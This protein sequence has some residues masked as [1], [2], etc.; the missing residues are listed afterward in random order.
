MLSSVNKSKT[1]LFGAI[2]NLDKNNSDKADKTANG[3]C[4]N[5]SIFGKNKGLQDKYQAALAN[6]ENSK[7]M[8]AFVDE[9]LNNDINDD[10][11]VNGSVINNEIQNED[12]NNTKQNISKSFLSENDIIAILKDHDNGKGNVF[13]NSSLLG[14]LDLLDDGIKN[15][16]VDS[17]KYRSSVVESAKQAV[18]TEEAKDLDDCN[19]DNYIKHYLDPKDKDEE[20]RATTKV[21]LSPEALLGK[22]TKDKVLAIAESCLGANE[23]DGSYLKFGESSHWC[24]AFVNYVFTQANNGVDP[25]SGDAKGSHYCPNYT[26][27]AQTP[28]SQGKTRWTTKS[29]DV[30][31]GDI[32]MFSND[33]KTS[34]HIGIIEKIDEDG[35]IHTI[36]GNTSDTCA[37]RK[38]AAGDSRVQGFIKMSG[39]EEKKAA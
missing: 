12:I 13:T 14:E 32:I 35:T 34:S 6:G 15:T 9:Y 4:G 37:R 39:S 25:F 23:A 2:V 17:S 22:D 7:E 38:Y 21:E 30:G 26:N 11:K 19:K 27:W 20:I 29:S 31:Q 28:D 1:T 33:G 10:G 16:S 3:K 8:D 5:V 18:E 24:A 36:E